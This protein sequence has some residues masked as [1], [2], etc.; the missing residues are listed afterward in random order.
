MCEVV[1]FDLG[2][3]TGTPSHGTIE[4]RGCSVASRAPQ[5]GPAPTFP[6][7]GGSLLNPRKF[8][9]NSSKSFRSVRATRKWSIASAFRASVARRSG[10]AAAQSEEST[11]SS[12]PGVRAK[13]WPMQ[14]AK[15]TDDWLWRSWTAASTI[16]PL[17]AGAGQGETQ[18][19]SGT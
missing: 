8:P 10:G 4:A 5:G 6:A 13:L 11:A 12:W 1:G 19:H 17:S 14:T 2:R 18:R 16:S 3:R 7:A 15:A 9:E